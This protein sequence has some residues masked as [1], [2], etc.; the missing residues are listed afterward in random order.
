MIES[1]EYDAA[2]IVTDMRKDTSRSILICMLKQQQFKK[3]TMYNS[4]L[5]RSWKDKKCL[6]IPKGPKTVER[7]TTQL[8]KEKWQK[9]K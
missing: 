3:F 6:K 1:V 7:Q 5:P 4:I 9:D 8:S 2:E